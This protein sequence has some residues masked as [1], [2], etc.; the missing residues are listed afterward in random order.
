MIHIVEGTSMVEGE[1]GREK[2]CCYKVFRGGIQGS[3][4]S[5]INDSGFVRQYTV[6]FQNHQWR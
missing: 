5:H 1:V 3:K 4:I 6:I 2:K